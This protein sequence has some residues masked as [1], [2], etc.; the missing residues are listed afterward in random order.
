[1]KH[2]DLGQQGEEIACAFLLQKGY[3]ILEKNWRYRK[4]EIDLIADDGRE[5]VFVEVKLRSADEYGSPRDFVG[6]TKQLNLIKAADAYLEKMEIDKNS[7][8]DIIGISLG[9][10]LEIEH[11]IDAFHT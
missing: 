1:M 3:H 11:I 7:R 8:F 9:N 10:Q 6:R 5:L 4:L 2:H